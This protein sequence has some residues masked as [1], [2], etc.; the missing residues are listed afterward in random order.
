MGIV[1]LE[2]GCLRTVLN[3]GLYFYSCL[4]SVKMEICRGTYTLLDHDE[5]S[6]RR[7]RR[8]ARQK[9][10]DQRQRGALRI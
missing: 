7:G 10:E 9:F 4:V 8:T 1:D 3:M 6:K 2:Q 5:E